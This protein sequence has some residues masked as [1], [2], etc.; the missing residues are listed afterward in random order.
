MTFGIWARWADL[1]S[2]WLVQL[3]KK[4]GNDWIRTNVRTSN[5]FTIYRLKPLGHISSRDGVTWTHDL[6]FPKQTRYQLRYIPDDKKFKIYLNEISVFFFRLLFGGLHPLKIIF[7]NKKTDNNRTRQYRKVRKSRLNKGRL[8]L[9]GPEYVNKISF[10]WQSNLHF[11]IKFVTILCAESLASLLEDLK[12]ALPAD[13]WNN[14][15]FETR[16]NMVKKTLLL[17]MRRDILVQKVVLFLWILKKELKLWKKAD[18]KGLLDLNFWET[19][20]FLKNFF[21]FIWIDI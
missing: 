12:L 10:E 9:E 7:A 20:C 1:C 21:F 14:I 3:S 16:S 5:R 6:L 11:F 15:F 18:L 2:T 4:N 17:V 19:R 13:I 8:S